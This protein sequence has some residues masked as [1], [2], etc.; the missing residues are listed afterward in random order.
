MIPLFLSHKRPVS[1]RHQWRMP[2]RKKPSPRLPALMPDPYL[3]K[4]DAR[5]DMPARGQHLVLF[6]TVRSLAQYVQTWPD[7]A[8]PLV[9]HTRTTSRQW[10]SAYRD[11]VTG[12]ASIVCATSRWLFFDRRYLSQVTI[13]QH[14]DRHYKRQQHPRMAIVTCARQMVDIYGAELELL[15]IADLASQL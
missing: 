2:K 9:V 5:T 6:P 10:R 7:A 3:T 11:I 8:E 4:R 1:Y 12:K 15:G 13:V 14:H